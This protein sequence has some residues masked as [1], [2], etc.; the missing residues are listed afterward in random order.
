MRKPAQ[1]QH[2]KVKS[3]SFP[4]CYLMPRHEN[5]GAASL[6]IDKYPTKNL[7]YDLVS[8]PLLL[9]IEIAVGRFLVFY[10]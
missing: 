3:L 4:D 6:K 8:P 7:P 1:R 10:Q 2:V 5:V 9:A